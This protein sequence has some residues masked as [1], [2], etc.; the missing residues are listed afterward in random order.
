[1][2]EKEKSHKIALIRIG[3]QTKLNKEIKD[4][5]NILSLHKKLTCIVLNATPPVLGMTKKVKDYITFGE[6]NEETLKLLKEKRGK[7]TKDKDGKAVY[8][9]FF[10]LHP[11][12]GGFERKGTKVAFT[13]GGALGDRKEKI[14]DLIKRML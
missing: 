12:K 9:K 2:N 5:L 8:K 7:K 13:A 14:N 1:M 10:R 3:G 4:T 11:P 6:I